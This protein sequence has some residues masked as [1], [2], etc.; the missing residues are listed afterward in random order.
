VK[1]TGI[2]VL[3]KESC[4]TIYGDEWRAAICAQID[5]PLPPLTPADVAAHRA[6]L[7]RTDIVLSG[8][9]APCFDAA[10]LAQMP[11]LQ[12]VLYGAGS[13]RGVVSD[14]FWARGVRICSAW[15][16]N[17]EPVAQYTLGV[18]LLSLK[19]VF[20]YAQHV[21]AQRAFAHSLPCAGGFRSTIGLV[22][23]GMIGRRVCELLR[24]FEL[25]VIAHD[26]YANADTARALG[27]T[28]CPLDQVFAEAD[29]VSLHTPWLPATEGMIT[30]AHLQAMKPGAT[31]I[32]TARGAVV[33]EA[34]L[35][36]TLRARPDLTAIL[37][38][39]HP[40]PPVAASPLYDL[41]N[42]VLTP[43]IAGSLGPECRRMGRMMVE[44]LQRYLAGQPLCWEITR[45]QAATLA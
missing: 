39:T 41:P 37:D 5:V 29:V 13:I 17:A 4:E 20:T 33:R 34:E 24:A 7:A 12:L 25:R 2:F 36:D 3:S 45:A 22:S 38:V 6:V 8:W 40:E 19:R 28:L 1:R 15:A 31:F 30:G 26:P 23:L 35:I 42:V 44:E 11:R 14:A 9:G 16:G 10:L 32:N 43:H 27:V 21:R 18:I